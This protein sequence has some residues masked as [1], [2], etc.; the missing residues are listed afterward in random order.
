MACFKNKAVTNGIASWSTT[1]AVTHH[2]N[3]HNSSKWGQECLQRVEEKKQ[4][5]EQALASAGSA[6]AGVGELPKDSQRALSISEAAMTRYYLYNPGTVSQRTFV[7]LAFRQMISSVFVAGAM[8]ATKDATLLASLKSPS[9]SVPALKKHVDDEDQLMTLYIEIELGTIF[10][11]H[12]MGNP[13]A[14]LLHDGADLNDKG[15]YNA[16]CIQYVSPA[17]KDVNFGA[18]KFTGFDNHV[19]CIGLDA[20]PSGHGTVTASAIEA[21]FQATTGFKCADLCHY[22]RSDRAAMSVAALISNASGRKLVPLPCGMH[23]WQKVAESTVA[24]LTKSKN[25][26]L[27]NACP[28]VLEVSKNAHEVAKHFDKVSR[29]KDLHEHCSVAGVPQVAMKKKLNVTRI[30]ADVNEM[31][32][33]IRMWKGIVS[34]QKAAAPGSLPWKPYTPESLQEL[35]E[36]YSVLEPVARVTTFVQNETQ[37]NAGYASVYKVLI[38]RNLRKEERAVIDL[39]SVGLAFPLATKVVNVTDMTGIGGLGVDRACAELE[40]RYCGSNS[41]TATGAEVV[42]TLEEK[43]YCLLDFRLIHCPHFHNKELY[44]VAVKDLKK[45]Y[46]E[47]GLK[48]FDMKTKTEPKQSYSITTTSQ[49]SRVSLTSVSIGAGFGMS[50][51]GGIGAGFGMSSPDSSV[52]SSNA[53]ERSREEE[54]SRLKKEAKRCWAPFRDFGINVKWEERYDEITAPYDLMQ[55]APVDIGALYAE[56]YNDP[57]YGLYPQMALFSKYSIGS[58]LSEGMCERVFSSCNTVMNEGR[59]LLSGEHLEKIIKLRMNA[60]F[61]DKMRVKYK[62]SSLKQLQAE[63]ARIKDA[64]AQF[65]APASS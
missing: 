37:L 8:Q 43:M 27:Q 57:A 53:E 40:R 16:T 33:V 26:V 35:V 63:A 60:A 1:V 5:R 36:L 51:S 58:V 7:S 50:S 20:V 22:V 52:T 29:L 59:T 21:S 38:A 18:R 10:L 4:K 56:I 39:E 9:L 34:Y 24:T 23:D 3:H 46:V 17:G 44:E 41:L 15:K 54:V 12:S 14:M 45:A 30:A 61:M 64:Y 48:L 19:I 31:G 11:S 47:Y 13:C 25:K 28:Q 62:D 2:K 65:K 42:F 32:Q 55:L 6:S 49:R